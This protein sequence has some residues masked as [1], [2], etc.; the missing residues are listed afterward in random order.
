MA[1]EAP[2]SLADEVPSEAP[3]EQTEEVP[4]EIPPEEPQGQSISSMVN[5]EYL[6]M[7]L[8]MGFSQAVCEKALF[9]T[10]NASVEV[11]MGWI[12]EN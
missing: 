3:A 7:L 12:E 4:P 11:A 2:S 8:S 10:Q 5:Q 9:L 6:A 1:E